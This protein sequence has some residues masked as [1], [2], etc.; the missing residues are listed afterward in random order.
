MQA[1]LGPAW[2]AVNLDERAAALADLADFVRRLAGESAPA[3]N[4][5]S[6]PRTRRG[7]A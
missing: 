6:L 7:A 4:V 5:V 1:A 3:G 2:R